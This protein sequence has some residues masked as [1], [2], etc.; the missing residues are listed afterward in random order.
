MLRCNF[1]AS[2]FYNKICVQELCKALY[3]SS[4]QL[5]A[6]NHLS[7]LLII[8]RSQKDSSKA[9]YTP[10]H[11]LIH[12]IPDLEAVPQQ[13]GKDVASVLILVTIQQAKSQTTT[14]C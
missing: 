11:L 2:L 7:I 8:Y 5:P 14:L 12:P 10:D 4:M 13:Q 1:L 3:M 9:R 6:S